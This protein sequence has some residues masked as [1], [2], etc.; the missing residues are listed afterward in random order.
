[1]AVARNACSSFIAGHLASTV[2]RAAKH[3]VEF[4][5]DHLFDELSCPSTHFGLQWIKPVVKKINSHLGCW[6]QRIR[7]RGNDRHG[8]VSY[9]TLQR[10][11]IRG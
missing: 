2:T 8:V 11:M 4:A 6:L 5:A 7:L 1:V 3:S 9:L 10:Q